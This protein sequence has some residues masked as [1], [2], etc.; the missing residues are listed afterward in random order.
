VVIGLLK[1]SLPEATRRRLTRVR[2]GLTR[3]HLRR[4]YLRLPIARA[5]LAVDVIRLRPRRRDGARLGIDRLQQVLVINLENR[6]ERL[7]GVM[8]ELKRL[9]IDTATRFD[10]IADRSGIRGCTLSHAAVMEQMIE[11]GWDCVMVV[12]DDARFAVDRDELDV[13][14]EAFLADEQAE[15]ACL[16]YWHREVERR[17]L[18]YLRTTKSFT[19]ACYLVKASI[20]GDLAAVWEE[21]ARRLGEGADR[22]LYGLDHIWNDLQRTRVFVIPIVRAVHQDAGYSDIWKTYVEP[23]F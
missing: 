6:P 17:S 7:A 1:R 4:R 16:A 19:T 3:P 11:R 22:E 20:A 10:A 21:G 23:T 9:G 14:V 2:D 13:L 18:L 15:V 8:T 5:A 12:E